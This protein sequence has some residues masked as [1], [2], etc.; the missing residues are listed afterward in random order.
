M[1]VIAVAG[2]WNSRVISSSVDG[3]SVA[4]PVGWRE[5]VL[6]TDLRSSAVHTLSLLLPTFP[7]G[8]HTNFLYACSGSGT[9]NVP[10]PDRTGPTLFRAETVPETVPVLSLIQKLIMTVKAE[11]YS[12]SQV[13]V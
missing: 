11:N 5:Q 12:L 10:R 1:G 13:T 2:S 9:N 3:R 7:H 4:R 6:G 8:P